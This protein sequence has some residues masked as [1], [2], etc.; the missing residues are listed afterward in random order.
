MSFDWN[1]AK[2]YIPFGIQSILQ[3]SGGAKQY[4]EIFESLYSGE[5]M[6]SDSGRVGFIADSFRTVD[7]MKDSLKSAQGSYAIS[8]IIAESII[9]NNLY[10]NLFSEKL[11]DY[12]SDTREEFLNGNK[13]FLVAIDS[14]SHMQHEL[15]EDI[16]EAEKIEQIFGL[17]WSEES[18][19]GQYTQGSSPSSRAGDLILAARKNPNIK[20][21]LNLIGNFVRIYSG[22]K[23][24][25]PGVNPEIPQGFKFSSDLTK[26][27]PSEMM[28]LCDEV[29]QTMFEIN[30][31]EGNLLSQDYFSKEEKG[32][33]DIHA[34]I[35]CSYS[36]N[37]YFLNSFRRADL[38][39]ALAGAFFTI[40]KNEQLKS[41]RKRN[42][43]CHFF[44][45][46]TNTVDMTDK[47]IAD[48]ISSI[49]TMSAPSGGTNPSSGIL[50]MI[51]NRNKIK[52]NFRSDIMMITDGAFSVSDSTTIEIIKGKSDGTLHWFSLLLESDIT[53][54]ISDVSN[55]IFN[56]EHIR[57]IMTD[58]NTQTS[59]VKEMMAA[60]KR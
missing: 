38:A 16:D 26:V 17:G 48:G 6:H 36:M 9:D 12:S 23:N 39:A 54:F 8:S 10:Q 55:F 25:I 60:T 41:Q 58:T 29:T 1:E 30:M 33:G 22:L 53:D 14:L 43:F 3:G 49:I 31:I 35:D 47:S 52:D 44:N 32:S 56:K 50:R 11:D 5:I 51:G 19:G 4:Q 13:E 46:A 20:D 7:G 18:S 59:L 21:I 42:F 27:V 28:L 45:D 34:F 2:K 37:T 15:L 24:T 57:K 40:F